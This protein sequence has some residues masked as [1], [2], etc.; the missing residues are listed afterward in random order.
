MKQMLHVLVATQKEHY[1]AGV[2]RPATTMV[3][4]MWSELT[5]SPL[6]ADGKRL[7]GEIT[8]T[9]VTTELQARHIPVYAFP[10]MN[11]ADAH[12]MIK[13]MES[14]PKRPPDSLRY[15]AKAGAG[16][17]VRRA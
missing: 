7:A 13:R 5:A 11:D 10:Y 3:T 2:E 14:E 4:E 17:R 6:L 8:L 15:L 12:R 9:D 16:D 1:N